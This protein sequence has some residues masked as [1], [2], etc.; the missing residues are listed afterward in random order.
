MD[1]LILKGNNRYKVGRNDLKQVIIN[2]KDE[3]RFCRCVD[4][5]KKISLSFLKYFA[6]YWLAVLDRNTRIR[7]TTGVIPFPSISKI[8]SEVI[9]MCI[10]VPFN[11]TDCIEGGFPLS[12]P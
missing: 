8:Y 9:F 7:W 3:R 4:Q 1:R 6:E 5:P 2:T 10:P 12:S 11:T